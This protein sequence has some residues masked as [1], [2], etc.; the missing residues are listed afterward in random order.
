[1]TRTLVLSINTTWNLVNFRRGLIRHL[2]SEGYR[3]VT[4]SP[5]DD[6]VPALRALG[7]EVLPMPMAG[8]GTNPVQDLALWWRYRQALKRLCPVAYLGWT[9]K[10]NIY[11]GLA[12]HSLGIP[13]INNISGLGATFMKPGWLQ[14]VAHG[15]YRLAL[16]RSR[17]VFFQNPDD[18][19]LFVHNRLVRAEQT[20]L[21]PGSGIDLAH[22]QVAPREP[23][24][25]RPFRFLMVARLLRDKGVLEYVEAARRLRAQGGEVT[26]QILGFLDVANPSAISRTEMDAWMAE[27]VVDYLG[28]TTD[29]RPWIAQADCVVL[30]SYREGTPRTLLEAAAMGRPLIATDVPGCRE[31][32]VNEI[33]GLLCEARSAE[34]L[35]AAM[36][37]LLAS[38][39]A[40]WAS[41]ANA[42][43]ELMV[44]R[45]D[46]RWV[47]QAYS[48]A[49]AR[50]SQ[51]S[52]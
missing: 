37:R 8:Q 32:V 43:R 7:C 10:P 2:Q 50:L 51:Q 29:V 12:A 36:T 39:A 41:M 16:R 24:A 31:V 20:A 18:R 19:D 4:L 22:F 49:L 42:G 46:E 17:Q 21:L 38:D 5:P 34:S 28:S 14:T 1:M 30:P 26:F 35:T 3:I 45:F 48:T 33:N 6:S 13:V 27:G 25:G 40:T 11:G 23:L 47:L 9:I 44:S 15:L 52:A